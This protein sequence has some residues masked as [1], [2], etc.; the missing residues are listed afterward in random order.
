MY[1][2]FHA[3][4][5]ANECEGYPEM[6]VGP[7]C[8]IIVGIK[9]VGEAKGR[10]ALPPFMSVPPF[11]SGD[12]WSAFFAPAFGVENNENDT[13]NHWVIIWTRDRTSI[14]PSNCIL[15]QA[16]QKLVKLPRIGANV[17]RKCLGRT[18]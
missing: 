15:S 5:E 4:V 9:F 10:M 8:L 12:G 14:P 7:P 17:K 16:Y 2:L 3:R 18:R 13:M 6:L 1:G 11:H